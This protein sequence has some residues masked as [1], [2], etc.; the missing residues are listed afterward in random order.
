M[1]EN[2]SGVSENDRGF[3]ENAIGDEGS[4][5][6]RHACAIAHRDAMAVECAWCGAKRTP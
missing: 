1:G 2:A 4:M 6:V 3:L 5:S